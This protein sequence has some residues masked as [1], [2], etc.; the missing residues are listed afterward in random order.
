MGT[1]PGQMAEMG[2]TAKKEA[3]RKWKEGSGCGGGAARPS[4]LSCLQQEVRLG[5][6]G[7]KAKKQ[8]QLRR[9]ETPGLHFTREKGN[10]EAHLGSATSA[11][12]EVTCAHSCTHMQ[13]H[14]QVRV[15]QGMGTQDR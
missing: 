15:H 2:K 7:G 8:Q 3:N 4:P 5:V 11:C 13:G 9:A 14:R 1:V 10:L 6:G 12:P